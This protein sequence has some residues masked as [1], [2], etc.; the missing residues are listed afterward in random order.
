MG[1]GLQPPGLHQPPTN[2]DV[3]SLLPP[4]LG[5]I[6]TLT[7]TLIHTTSLDEM[8][9][10]LRRN[11]LNLYK[12]LNQPTHLYYW[13]GQYYYDAYAQEPRMFMTLL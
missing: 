2:T 5:H 10:T 1:S 3:I 9:Q 6:N 12:C 4:T 11:Y 7:L 8:Y 13:S